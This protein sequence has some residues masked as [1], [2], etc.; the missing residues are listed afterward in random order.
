M[1]HS[2]MKRAKLKTICC[3]ENV[4]SLADWRKVYGKLCGHFC[5]IA[6]RLVRHSKTEPFCWTFDN[7]YTNWFLNEYRDVMYYVLILNCLHWKY[8]RRNTRRW[9]DVDCTQCHRKSKPISGE[10]FN[11]SSKRMWCVPIGLIRTLPAK[12]IQTSILWKIFYWTMLITIRVCR[13]FL[14]PL[15]I[16]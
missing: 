15:Y 5:C 11:V 10:P 1:A 13:E 3:C 12:T 9:P 2:W 6:I 4:Y 8:L 14:A 7:K 16:I